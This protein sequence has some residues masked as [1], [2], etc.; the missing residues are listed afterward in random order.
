MAGMHRYAR[1]K[2]KELILAPLM[3]LLPFVC[4]AATSSPLFGR[5]YTVIPLSRKVEFEGGDFES[6]SGWRLQLGHVVK[7]DDVAVTT[8]KEDLEKLDGIMLE[9]HGRGKAIEL[10]IQPGS[11]AIGQALDKNKQVLEE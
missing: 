11:V 4:N 9:T 5:G 8:L 2:H 10:S 1:L 7:P 6:G 3:L